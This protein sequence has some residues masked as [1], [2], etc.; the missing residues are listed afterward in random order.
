MEHIE[1]LKVAVEQCGTAGRVYSVLFTASGID[2]SVYDWGKNL[3]AECWGDK[4]KQYY[5]RV[6]EEKITVF[7]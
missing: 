6:G 4:R 3:V 2:V 1:P 5:R 7:K